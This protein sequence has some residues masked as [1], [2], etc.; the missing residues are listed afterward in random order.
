MRTLV[1]LALACLAELGFSQAAPFPLSAPVVGTASS[2]GL[3]ASG[4]FYDVNGDGKDDIAGLM[5]QTAL[6]FASVAMMCSVPG[7][8]YGAPTLLATVSRTRRTNTSERASW[9][10]PPTTAS[11][12]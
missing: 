7:G 4:R 9:R 2:M 6:G 5:N 1:L 3:Q 11:P 10:T 8:G 12:T